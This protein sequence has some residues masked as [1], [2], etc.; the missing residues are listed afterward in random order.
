MQEN[1][2][3][4]VLLRKG[5]SFFG[6]VYDKVSSVRA[7]RIRYR[8]KIWRKIESD[9]I[10]YAGLILLAIL[11]YSWN[12]VVY[13]ILFLLI[14]AFI[15]LE[16]PPSSHRLGHSVLRDL[17]HAIVY[18]GL[19]TGK[20]FAFFAP[21]LMSRSLFSPGESV[22]DWTMLEDHESDFWKR[23]RPVIQLK[24]PHPREPSKWRVEWPRDMVRETVVLVL[25]EWL[26]IHRPIHPVRVC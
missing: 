8:R 14:V 1:E 10:V 25:D 3:G 24:S 19:P 11:F 23:M 21:A 4:R 20:E 13:N 16:T 15:I 6:T 7:D 5:K 26:V 2:R 22:L 17:S 12:D 18:P 9:V